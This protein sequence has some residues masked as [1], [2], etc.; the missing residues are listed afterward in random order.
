MTDEKTPFKLQLENDLLRCELDQR[1]AECERWREWYET[2]VANVK[3]L[4][5][6]YGRV[7]RCCLFPSP[8][9]EQP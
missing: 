4:D 9:T 2:L 8:R 7:P 5:A 1:K 3:L 6:N